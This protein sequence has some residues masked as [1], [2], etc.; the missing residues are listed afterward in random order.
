MAY[1]HRDGLHFE[2]VAAHF[3]TYHT[4]L[5]V[6][7]L[8]LV[9]NEV[10]HAVIDLMATVFLDGLEGVGVVTHEHVGT[11]QNEHVGIV[12][13][14][15]NG[16]QLMLLSPMETDDDDGCGVLLSEMVHARE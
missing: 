3:Q 6:Q 2:A 15:E 13:L 10:T 16:L 7:G 8:V 9:E 5:A 1:F 4:G 12:P 14:T 11:C